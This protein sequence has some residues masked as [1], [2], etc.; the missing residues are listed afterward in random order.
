V[1][2]PEPTPPAEGQLS[3]ATGDRD[4]PNV[5]PVAGNRTPMVVTLSILGVIVVMVALLVG[6][7]FVAS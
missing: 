6:F 1:T 2:T 4:Q 3:G 7:S 5:G